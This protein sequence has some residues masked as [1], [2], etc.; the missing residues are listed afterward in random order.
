MTKYDHL[1]KDALLRLLQL[2]GAERQLGMVWERE[3]LDPEAVLNDDFVALDLDENLC[4]GD[5]PWQNLII[6]GDNY[7][8]LRALCFERILV[9]YTAT[10]TQVEIM[11]LGCRTRTGCVA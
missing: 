8:A 10:P 1:D 7:D 5:A 11:Y 6:E 3:E 2:R 4:R 9:Y